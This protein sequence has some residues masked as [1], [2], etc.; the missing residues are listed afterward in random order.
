MTITVTEDAATGSDGSTTGPESPAS[1]TATWDAAPTVNITG[2][3]PRI[4]STAAFPVTFTFSES[5]TDFVTGDVTVTGGTKGSLSGN[6]AT[7]TLE[8]TPAGGSDVTITVAANA[9]TD[10]LNTGPVSAVSAPQ[11]GMRPHQPLTSR[12]F[13]PASIP[14]RPS[15]SPLRFRNP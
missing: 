13:R 4:N 2:V 10:G 15:R 9:A 1:A 3:P 8:V 7:Y 12:A 14:R 11:S 5:V 6:G